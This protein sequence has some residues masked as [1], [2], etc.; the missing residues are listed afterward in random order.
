MAKINAW[1]TR[2][3]VEALDHLDETQQQTVATGLAAYARALA[4]CRD[5]ALCGYGSANFTDDRLPSGDDRP[6]SPDA[7]GVLRPSS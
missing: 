2:Q 5:S 6:D 3:V 1:G 4:Q 7:R